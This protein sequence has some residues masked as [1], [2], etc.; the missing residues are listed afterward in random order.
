M[1]VAQGAHVRFRG[2]KH[3][4]SC[5]PPSV[6]LLVPPQSYIPSSY[7]DVQWFTIIYE[8]RCTVIALGNFLLNQEK[9]VLQTKTAQIICIFLCLFT[10]AGSL[11]SSWTWV[12]AQRPFMRPEKLTLGFPPEMLSPWSASFV[13]VLCF[14]NLGLSELLLRPYRMNVTHVE[15]LMC[16]FD[17][18]ALRE[19]HPIASW[20]PRFPVRNQQSTCWGSWA[21]GV[22]LSRGVSLSCCFQGSLFLFDSWQ[23]DDAV[24]GMDCW[25]C[26]SF[27]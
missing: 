24:L 6:P 27:W 5:K 12:T 21:H 25:V 2:V 26:P 16:A 1:N 9:K 18:S 3:L 4:C 20:P 13:F 7:A 11:T 14:S 19:F 10:S 8:Q 22:S 15:S 23:F 17:L